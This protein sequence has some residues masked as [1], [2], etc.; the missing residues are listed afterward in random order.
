M[1]HVAPTE[2]EERRMEQRFWARVAAEAAEKATI[3]HMP[4][5]CGACLHKRH[6]GPCRVIRANDDVCGCPKTTGY[7][8]A[9]KRRRLKRRAL[10]DQRNAP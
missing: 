8:T 6:A 10:R 2:E 9:K 4:V 5:K 7:M 3:A 1:M